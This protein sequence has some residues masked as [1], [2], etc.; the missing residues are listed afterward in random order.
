MVDNGAKF[1]SIYGAAVGTIALGINIF[2]YLYSKKK[3]SVRLSVECIEGANVA[4]EIASLKNS[5]NQNELDAAQLALVYVVTVRNG[6]NIEAHIQEVG[7]VDEEGCEHCALVSSGPHLFLT[8]IARAASI[9]IS[10]KAKNTFNIY[11]R[12]NAPLFTAVKCFVVD[13]QQNKWEAKLKLASVGR[14]CAT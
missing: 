11:L 2:G 6:G 13:Q 14:H 1:L 4:K 3:D 7:I 9:S 12:R 8:E 10:P 5:A